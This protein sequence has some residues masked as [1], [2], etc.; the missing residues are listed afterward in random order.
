MQHPVGNVVV[1]DQVKN[2]S[3]I[4]VSRVG[5]GVKDSISIQGE[6]LPVAG[7]NDFLFRPSPGIPAHTGER[8]EAFL[9]FTV[10][11]DP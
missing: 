3:F 11:V 5:K 6:T 7:E 4:D 10:E 8:G 2:L 9:L 1:L